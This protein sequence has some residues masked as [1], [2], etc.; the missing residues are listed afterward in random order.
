MAEVSHESYVLAPLAGLKK[1]VQLK[2]SASTPQWPNITFI[3]FLDAP[4][5]EIINHEVFMY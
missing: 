5:K 2:K 1:M 3:S 4:R